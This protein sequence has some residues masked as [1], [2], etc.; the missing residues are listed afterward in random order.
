LRQHLNTESPRRK[1]FT[2]ILLLNSGQL[3][4]LTAIQ[5]EMK[6]KSNG[7][8]SLNIF[9]GL[10]GLLVHQDLRETVMSEEDLM[11]Q[12]PALRV[13]PENRE[14]KEKRETLEHREVPAIMEDL[15]CKA[16]LEKTD[17]LVIRVKK[18]HQVITGL[19]E[20]LANRDTTA[21]KEHL[22]YQAKTDIPVRRAYPAKMDIPEDLDPKDLKV[23]QLFIL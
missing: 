8:N 6:F 12:F 7:R 4:I 1:K 11:S 13:Q 21:R 20:L 2:A 9:P 5:L 22:V 10:R 3:S 15:D 18:D 14:K 17:R 23:I 16:H 19:R